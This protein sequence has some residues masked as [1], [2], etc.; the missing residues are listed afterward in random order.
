M[1]DSTASVLPAPLEGMFVP[2]GALGRRKRSLDIAIAVFLVLL[3][4]PLLL[5]IA[6]IVRLDSAGPAL[7]RQRRGGLGGAPFVIYKFRTMRVVEDGAAIRQASRNDLRCTGVGRVLRRLSLDELPQLFNV[8]RGE[9]SLVGPR[10]HALAHDAQ[11]LRDHPLYSYRFMVRPGITGLAQV[12]G[13]RG[14]IQDPADMAHRLERDLEY[15]RT[16]SF[17]GDVRILCATLR[18][19][20]DPRAY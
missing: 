15:V 10:P 11:F 6:I 19:P 1:F 20:T 12:S 3:L 14:E 4:L 17:W 2:R 18:C 16:W 8:L 9:M 5:A 13:W 7:F